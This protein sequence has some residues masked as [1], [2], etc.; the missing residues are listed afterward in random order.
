MKK[1]II[2]GILSLS[3]VSL[4]GQALEIIGKSP[5]EEDDKTQYSQF[6]QGVKVYDLSDRE[7]VVGVI[8]EG[9]RLIG[10][11]GRLNDRAA[12]QEPVASFYRG[13]MYLYGVST[14]I[15]TEKGLDMLEVAYRDGR[16]GSLEQREAALLL[17]DIYG[18]HRELSTGSNIPLY[19][20]EQN[21]SRASVM[22]HE[23]SLS[24]HP[25]AA[26]RLAHYYWEGINGF[27]QDR[28]LAFYWINS[29]A[30]QGDKDALRTWEEW[31][32]DINKTAEY[33]SY[34]GEVSRGQG[35]A[36]LEIA[37]IYYAGLGVP[38]DKERA[39]RIAREAKRLKIKGA[40]YY[41][42]TWE[43]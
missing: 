15:Q 21:K 34:R 7:G 23:A 10:G 5:F 11:S 30:S 27:A 28:D 43:K 26:K 25:I 24:G 31:Q 1:N 42:S 4:N 6:H 16:P 36:L 13:L 17:S 22:V 29:A 9:I 40:D 14:D 32:A 19:I 12:A 2:L 41:L 39:I 37:K 3:L 18:G 20:S 8:N 35:A 38:K 33:A